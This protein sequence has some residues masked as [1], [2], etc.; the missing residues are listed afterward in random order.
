MTAKDFPA[1][2]W[3][4]KA[5]ALDINKDDPV[6]AWFLS[7]EDARETCAAWNGK[8]CISVYRVESAAK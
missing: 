4:I 1:Y 3:L 2:G 6:Y 7:E 8:R 5:P